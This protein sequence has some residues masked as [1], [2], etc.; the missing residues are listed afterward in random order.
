MAEA[1]DIKI[2]VIMAD[3]ADVI[4]VKHNTYDEGQDSICP[5]VKAFCEE[6]KK[7]LQAAKQEDRPAVIGGDLRFDINVFRPTRDT[8][9]VEE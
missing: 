5:K 7:E 2:Y 1:A 9:P 4:V 8:R 3:E 6:I